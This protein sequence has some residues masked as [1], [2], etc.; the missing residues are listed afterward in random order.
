MRSTKF[1]LA[2]TVLLVVS[3]VLAP[4]PGGAQEIPL[5]IT[6][7]CKHPCVNKILFASGPQLDKLELHARI[8]PATSIDPAGETFVFELSNANGTIF[9]ATLPP[10]AFATS[11]KRYIYRN[12]A[13]RT[14][15]G[16][17]RVTISER[18]D[19][20]EGF[21]VDLLA[22]GDLSAATLADMTTIIAVGGDG[23]FNSGPWN[24]LKHGWSLDFAP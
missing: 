4:R 10:G 20:N 15:G 7:P 18:H 19:A 2:A 11:K 8:V 12:P 17:Y 6:R 22:Y 21:R 23:F 24:Q 14:A 13:A 5:P 9:S 16:L 1:L 3:A